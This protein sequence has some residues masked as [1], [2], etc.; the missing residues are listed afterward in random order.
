[1]SFLYLW[2]GCC[3]TYNDIHSCV[4]SGQIG[5]AQVLQKY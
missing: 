4:M 3:I 1:M 2:H 5:A